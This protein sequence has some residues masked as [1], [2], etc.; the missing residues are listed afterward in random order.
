MIIFVVF[1]GIILWMKIEA[2][3]NEVNLDGGGE[4]RDFVHMCHVCVCLCV[5]A[6]TASEST[7][8]SP[9]V[10]IVDSN[11]KMAGISCIANF[12][13]ERTY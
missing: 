12:G 13:N 4:N 7:I 9:V 8:N 10:S 1:G 6:R 11:R 2:R 3:R 5:R